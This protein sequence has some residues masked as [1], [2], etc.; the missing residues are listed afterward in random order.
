M[1][2]FKVAEISRMDK[3][4]NKAWRT[5]YDNHPTSKLRAAGW[6]EST[7]AE[8][9]GGEVGEEWKNR[10][11][12]K[13][14]GKEYV[15]EEKK[16]TLSRSLGGEGKMSNT[17]SGSA[18]I[19]GGRT[20]TVESSPS[21]S[22]LGSKKAQNEAYFARLGAQN[23]SRSATL[24][25][26]QGGRYTGFGSDTAPQ[27]ND[28]AGGP[29]MPGINDFQKDPVAALTKGFGWFSSAV[30]KGAKTVNESIIQPAAQKVNILFVL[31]LYSVRPPR[32]FSSSPSKPSQKKAFSQSLTKPDSE[33]PLR[34]RSP[35]PT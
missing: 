35:K 14:E 25:P 30:G 32:F 28:G 16:E 11:T 13:V 18:G 34:S 29:S 26:S 15:P 33:P 21:S 17:D 6:E 12:A 19:S 9:Y 2:A 22:S 1:D 20:N 24:P 4:G 31:C 3:G 10:L 7:I 27:G 23:L 8:R 5:F